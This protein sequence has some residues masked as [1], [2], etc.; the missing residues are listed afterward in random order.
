MERVLVREDRIALTEV[1]RGKEL[2][3]RMVRIS[4]GEIEAA[5]VVGEDGLALFYS[6]SKPMDVDAVS[7]CTTALI[8][9]L[10]SGLSL[11]DQEGFDRVDVKLG[12]NSHLVLVPLDG[13]LLVV[14]TR[15]NPN[16][17]L[18]YLVIERFKDRILELI[19]RARG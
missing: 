15:A 4:G 5:I 8:G 1:K 14:K 13:V 11:L 18:V 3:D 19:A 9:A 10:T 12:D 17:G 2:L 16:I 6:S 7:A